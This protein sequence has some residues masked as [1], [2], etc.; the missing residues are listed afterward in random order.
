VAHEEAIRL[1]RHALDLQRRHFP[2]THDPRCALLLGLGAAQDSSGASKASRETFLEAAVSARVLGSAAD[3][4]RAAIGFERAGWRLGQPETQAV[5]LLNEALAAPAS[6]GMGAGAYGMQMFSIRREQGRL[7]EVLPVLRHFVATQPDSA[8]WRPGLALLYMELDL[9]D[10]AQAAFEALAAD[11]FA[12][13]PHSGLWP[14][15]MA[16]LAEVCAYLKDAARAATLYRL[17]SPYA[18]RN[19][20]T[21]NNAPC[22]GSADR[23]L[24]MLKATVGEWQAAGLSNQEIGARVFISTHTVAHMRSILNKTGAANRTEAAAYAARQGLTS[25]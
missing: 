23:F 7:A 5:T 17:R 18:G 8:I 10:E 22:F 16:F 4:I 1:Y 9:R 21:G 2:D 20:A 24:A 25:G 11:D 12:A 19:L 6:R 14:T 3:L 13:I 15:S